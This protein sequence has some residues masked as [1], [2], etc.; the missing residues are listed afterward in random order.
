MRFEGLTDTKFTK[1]TDA[2]TARVY[3]GDDGTGGKSWVA[4]GTLY[5]T[6]SYTYADGSGCGKDLYKDGKAGGY[7][8]PGPCK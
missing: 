2:Q 5:E 3:G 6:S 1:L 4:D 8:A 7:S